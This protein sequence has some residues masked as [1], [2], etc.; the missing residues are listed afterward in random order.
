[1]CL[2]YL[3]FSAD[4]ILYYYFCH[5]YYKI[6]TYQVQWEV[7]VR[8]T[9]ICR[10]TE[11]YSKYIYLYMDIYVTYMCMHWYLCGEVDQGYL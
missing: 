1:M 4:D 10:G 2:Y 3:V 8:N 9:G 5:Q 6:G 7:R 11:E